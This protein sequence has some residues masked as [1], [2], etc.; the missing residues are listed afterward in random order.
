[1]FDTSDNMN[2]S[3]MH[4]IIYDHCCCGCC[5][6]ELNAN[7]WSAVKRNSRYIAAVHIKTGASS[8]DGGTPRKRMSSESRRWRGK[9]FRGGGPA[10][11]MMMMM[12]MMMLLL[13]LLLLLLLTSATTR[14]TP[15]CW[16]LANE[17]QPNYT[18][19]WWWVYTIAGSL[20]T[21]SG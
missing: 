10:T 11:V 17:Y 1:M 18:K 20:Q 15:L 13:L 9:L 7:L 6:R 16:D 5:K 19:W 14:S 8:A 4:Q 3:H 2:C 12:M 21:D